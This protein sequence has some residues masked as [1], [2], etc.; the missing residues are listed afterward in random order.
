MESATF[1]LAYMSRDVSCT[2][3]IEVLPPSSLRPSCSGENSQY[4]SG[5]VYKSSGGSE[6][7]P[8]VQTGTPGPSLGPGEV[9]VAVDDTC[10]IYA[11]SRHPVEIGVKTWGMETLTLVVEQI[12]KR[13]G[14]TEVEVFGS[15]EKTHCH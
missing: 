5:L 10:T 15:Q 1:S 12:W 9:S 3:S 2:L 14:H 7:V 4:D 8:S 13:Y 11:W 6:V